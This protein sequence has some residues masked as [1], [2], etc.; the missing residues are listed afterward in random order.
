MSRNIDTALL[1][2]FLAVHDTGSLTAAAAL[3]HLTQG[4]V[5]QQLQRLEALFGRT[6]L[7]RRRSGAAL[8]G[9][10][11]RLLGRAR[12][13]VRLNDE[14]MQHMT[15]AGCVGA[16]RLGVPHD[17]IGTHLP[18]LLR[19]YSLRY[20]DVDISL[21][22]ATSPELLEQVRRRKLDLTLAEEPIGAAAGG[23][24]LAVD[25]VVW[26]AAPGGQAWRKNPLPVSLVSDACAF[27][28]V[29]ADALDGGRIPWRSVFENGNA[30]A[31]LT[32]VRLDLAVTASLLSVA[33]ADLQVLDAASGLPALP[34]YAINLYIAPGERSQ[35]VEEMARHIR[36]AYQE[37]RPAYAAAA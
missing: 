7:E 35:A 21:I 8:T 1:R 20:P 31:T 15:G 29:L 32:T 12:E 37:R 6:L 33:P 11:A 27:R 28:P 22:S 25:R 5:S 13:M 14:L 3:L 2:A 10:G 30:D 9:D 36:Q 17:L 16:V 34:D 23:E 26:L 19:A 24:R 18:G 4:A